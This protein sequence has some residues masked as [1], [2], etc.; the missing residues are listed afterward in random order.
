MKKVEPEKKTSEEASGGAAV[1]AAAAVPSLSG[2]SSIAGGSCSYVGGGERSRSEV[3]GDGAWG[4]DVDADQLKEREAKLERENAELMQQSFDLERLVDE[5]RAG[6]EKQSRTLGETLERLEAAQEEALQLEAELAKAEEE[7][8]AVEALRNQALHSNDARASRRL[9][10]VADL[11]DSIRNED[12]KFA[13]AKEALVNQLAATKARNRL[14]EGRLG[15][16]T[17]TSPHFAFP[18]PRT[19]PCP[20]PSA[21]APATVHELSATLASPYFTPPSALPT[22][23][24]APPNPS[25]HIPIP[26]FALTF[27]NCPIHY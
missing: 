19:S 22:P 14:L 20:R 24:P 8:V 7:A 25:L 16:P 1:V 2:G 10:L 5:A 6:R 27:S 26:D 21:S 9:R 13:E 18:S 3:R 15:S 4:A 17:A 23:S 11:T 12:R